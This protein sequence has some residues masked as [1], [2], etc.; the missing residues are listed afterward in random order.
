MGYPYSAGRAANDDSRATRSSQF[1]WIQGRHSR[2]GE[3]HRQSLG[4]VQ[5]SWSLGCGHES[6]GQ[7]FDR[8]RREICSL[9]KDERQSDSWTVMHRELLEMAPGR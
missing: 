1:H 6:W 8:C 3:L 4:T 7:R 5:R 2:G 9:E